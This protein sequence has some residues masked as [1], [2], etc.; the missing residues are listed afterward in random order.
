MAPTT[1][2]WR[3][4]KSGR[5][6]R[7]KQAQWE[8]AWVQKCPASI[9]TIDICEYPHKGSDRYRVVEP[10]SL[11]SSGWY[12][13]DIASA[14]TFALGLGTLLALDHEIVGEKLG[15]RKHGRPRILSRH[16]DDAVAEDVFGGGGGGFEGADR[17]HAAEAGGGD[18]CV[19][20][21][22]GGVGGGLG[23]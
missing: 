19:A 14:E 16:Q 10:N 15:R 11:L 1:Q 18:E 6:Q 8:E 4:R 22:G 7:K 5:S 21:G 17:V 20:P 3:L 9:W 12:R 2:A 13:A 23:T